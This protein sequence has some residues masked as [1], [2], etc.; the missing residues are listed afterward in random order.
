MSS[1]VRKIAEELRSDS[2]FLRQLMVKAVTSGPEALL[3]YGPLLFGPAFA[4]GLHDKRACVRRNLR[5]ILGPRPPLEE[6]TDIA[7]VFTN[8]A[9]C[10]TEA[11]LLG[12]P[13]GRALGLLSNALG[14]DNYEA[15]EAVGKGIVIA[16]AHLGGWEVA[17]PMLHKVRAKNVVVVMAR[18][19]D[20]RARAMQDELR[21]RSGVKVVH[22]GETALDALPLLRHLQQDDVVA[23]QIDRVPPGMRART[24]T[25]CG[26]PFQVPEG[27]LTIAALSGAPIMPVFTRRLGFMHYEAKVLPPI[28]VPRRPTASDL[29]KAAQRLMDELGAFLRENPTQWFHFV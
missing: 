2:A 15:C 19:R 11:M 7:A 13:R 3:R 18:E 10:M 14:V 25:L 5:R 22:I 20:E 27:P 4:A 1:S 12:T 6:L 9:S 28:H 21:A 26:A 23:M 29:D 8:Y 17:G 16:T 24:V